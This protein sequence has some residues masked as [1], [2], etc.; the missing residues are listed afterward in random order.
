MSIYIEKNYEIIYEKVRDKP[1][2]YKFLPEVFLEI[3]SSSLPKAG[4]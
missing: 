4:L 3:L 1:S 2:R